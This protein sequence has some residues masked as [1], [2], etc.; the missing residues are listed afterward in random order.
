MSRT[1]DLKKCYCRNNFIEYDVDD[2]D[3]EFTNS[4]KEA[5]LQTL[6]KIGWVAKCLASSICIDSGNEHLESGEE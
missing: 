3:T 4:L 1:Y 2:C 6:L 5:V